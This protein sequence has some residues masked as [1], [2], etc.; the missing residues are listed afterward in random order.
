[1]AA[2]QQTHF[3]KAKE[4][5]VHPVDAHAPEGRFAI[6]FDRCGWFITRERRSQRHAAHLGVSQQAPPQLFLPK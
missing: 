3:E 1:M 6:R 2:S 5:K 4:L